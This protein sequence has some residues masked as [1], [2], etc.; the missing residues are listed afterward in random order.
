M[1]KYIDSI[2]LLLK[3]AYNFIYIFFTHILDFFL[4]VDSKQIDTGI[5]SLYDNIQGNHPKTTTFTSS[6][7]FD[8][9]TNFALSIT[10]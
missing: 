4:V 7:T 6:L 10:Q 9:K 1:Y 2:I 8:T 3:V 5:C